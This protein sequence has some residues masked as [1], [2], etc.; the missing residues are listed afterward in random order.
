MKYLFLF[1]LVSL[2]FDGYA[3]IETTILEK[4]VSFGLQ[5][6]V[7]FTN[8]PLVVREDSSY[9]FQNKFTDQSNTLYFCS[10][11]FDNDSIEVYYKAINPSVQYP[12][13]KLKYNIFYDI[14]KHHRLERG[15]RKF[16]IIVGGYGKSFEKQVQSY[17]KRLKS[18]YGDSLTNKALIAVFAWGT[19]DDAVQ[20]YNAVRESK[21]AAADF[22]IYQHMLDEFISDSD[23][24]SQNPKDFHITILFSSIGNNLFKEY[25]QHREAQD[26]PLLKTYYRILFFGSVAPRNSFEEGKAFENLNQMAD[27][28]DV[29]V[30]SKDILLK[31]S[32]VAHLRSRMGNKGPRKEDELPAY[33]NVHHIEEMI[34]KEDMAAL[35][36]DY[37]LTNEALQYSI[38][39]IVNDD[40]VAKTY[41]SEK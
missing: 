18:T 6:S 5:K 19:E 21:K 38:M 17:M 25:V 11:C 39:G 26:I 37:L 14:Y 41:D 20:Y 34:T 33:I 8:R 9:T 15:I 36:H 32:S 35:G 7:F 4:S 3:Q 1:I 23:F 28:V 29:F 13:E 40:P 16:Y 10:Y 22:A 30:S 27:S 12:T 31:M 24:F 2:G